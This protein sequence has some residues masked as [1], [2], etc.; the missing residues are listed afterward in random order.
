[1][2]QNQIERLMH[3]KHIQQSLHDM[4]Q[5]E[6][7]D[8]LSSAVRG[9][10]K[11][12]DVSEYDSK[13]ARK[14]YLRSL[15]L[16]E[17]VTGLF[18]TIGIHCVNEMPYVSIASM[19][20]IPG[21]SK[22]DSIKTVSEL[23]ALFKPVGLYEITVYPDGTRTVESNIEL[24]EQL[25]NRLNLY[26]YLPPMVEKPDTLEHNKSSGYKTI[27]SDSLILG[28]SENFHKNSISLDV[29]NTLNKTQYVLDTDF[30]S[31]HAK[32]WHRKEL[33][34]DEMLAAYELYSID[35]DVTYEQF[36]E[37]YQQDCVNWENYLNQFNTLKTHL[38]DKTIYF[39]HKVD[40]RGRVYS[41][42]FHFNYQGTSFEK[43]CISLAKKETVEGEL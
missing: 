2:N 5:E 42:A 21:M 1:M 43:A 15:D 41:Q 11:W 6:L 28:H 31:K 38:E 23:I 34:T 8:Y 20:S 9:L 35:H 7:D 18:T 36:I 32:E 25:L 27:N 24:N 22:L 4:I 29:L 10:R 17:I 33:T 19:Y 3:P 13:N 37:Q 39:T 16:Y 12:L 14:E 26:C 30:I 40:K